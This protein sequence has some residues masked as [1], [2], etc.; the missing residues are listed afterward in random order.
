MNCS[1]VKLSRHAIQRIYER[2]LS[3]DTV[4]DIVTYGESIV[5]YPNDTPFPSTLLKGSHEKTTVHVVVARD[6]DT[7]MC[8]IVTVYLPDPQRW[9]TTFSIRKPK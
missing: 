8:I 7:G 4:L 5:E 3:L 1:N 9:D 6:P 2:D